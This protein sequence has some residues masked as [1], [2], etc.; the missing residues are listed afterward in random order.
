M[1]DHLQI[2]HHEVFRR[3]GHF[4]A[5]P[6]NYGLWA[7]DEE[8]VVVFADGKLGEQGALHAR[9]KSQEFKPMQA[10][11]V[12][13]GATWSPETFAG[14]VPGGKS[15]SA[16]EHLA[17]PL[18][19][20]SKLR[21]QDIPALST[22]VNFLD[23][24]IAV[25]V[26]RTGLDGRAH[27]WFYLTRN[28]GRRWEGPFLFKGLDLKGLA[29]RTDIVPLSDD[30]ALFMMTA[31]KSDGNEGRCLCVETTDGGLTFHWKSS[32]PFDGDGYAI[33]PSSLRLSDGAIVS[34]VRRGR[35]IDQA[36]WLETFRSEDNGATWHPLGIP[37]EDTG[38]GGNP[39]SLVRLGPQRLA[40]VYGFRGDRPGMRMVTS[41]DGGRKWSEAIDIRRDAVLPDIGYPRSVALNDGRILAIYYYNFGKER[42]IAAST[43][44]GDGH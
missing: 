7:W 19:S 1:S 20:G 42:F 39:G 8:I 15:L 44:S 21:G 26:A 29:S 28:R 3:P 5:W 35:G 40:L 31:A 6:A 18:R 36:G 13:G 27:S 4:S 34:V 24:E 37:V 16:D 11:S 32:L 14:F 43:I 25:L 17:V 38:P 33:M 22:P 30:H 12:D 23:P 2:S 10:R 41:S 9:D